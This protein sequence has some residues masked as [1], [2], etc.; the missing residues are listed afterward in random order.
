MKPRTRPLHSSSTHYPPKH[1]KKKQ[2]KRISERTARC[3][4]PKSRALKKRTLLNFARRFQLFFLAQLSRQFFFN[5]IRAME[6]GVF[7]VIW[8][9]IKTRVARS[10]SRRAMSRARFAACFYFPQH[11]VFTVGIWV[12]TDLLWS[13]S[14]SQDWRLLFLNNDKIMI[15]RYPIVASIL[16]SKRLLQ[17]W[18]FDVLN[19]SKNHASLSLTQDAVI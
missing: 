9:F 2:K 15:R 11:K 8:C 19:I 4:I 17:T 13:M 18:P 1:R 12:V 16:S 7:A 3:Q 5:F 10:L 14:L 6:E